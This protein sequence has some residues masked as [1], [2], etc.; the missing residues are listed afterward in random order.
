M[1]L[2]TTPT[3]GVGT[4]FQRRD[5]DSSGSAYTTISNIATISGPGFTRETVDT[6]ALDT[7]G[8]YRT[9]LTGFRDAGELTFTMMFYY[10][11][12]DLLKDDFESDSAAHYRITLPDSYST[13]IDFDGLVTGMPMTIPPD[14]KVTCDVTIKISGTVTVQ[15]GDSSGAA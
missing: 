13:R 9:F 5:E 15:M 2:A 7:T 4:I 14:E 12:F 3:T 1:A 6:T 11:G 8:G 10:G